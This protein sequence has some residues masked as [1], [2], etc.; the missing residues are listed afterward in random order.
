M[1]QITLILV[2]LGLSSTVLAQDYSAAKPG[3]L[4][5]VPLQALH[6]TQ[7]A[8]GYDQIYYKLG[9][10]AQ[11]RNKL[12]DEYCEANGQGESANVPGDADLRK[13]ESFTCQDK[14]G[15]RSSEM[16]T[17]VIGPEGKLFLT[18]GHHTFTVLVEHPKGGENLNMWVRVTDNFSDSADI[19]SFWQR[20]AQ[21]RKVWLKDGNG[22]AIDPQQIPSQLGLQHLAND[23]YRALVYFTREVGYDKPRSGEVAPE[24]LEFYWGNWLRS[25]MSL[26]TYDLSDRGDYRDAVE[27]AAKKM[28]ALAPEDEVGSSG[29]KARELGVYSSMDRKELNKVA[30]RKLNYATS[31]K[32][33]LA[34]KS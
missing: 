31:Y 14:V 23:P 6:P 11:E 26:D 20:M 24:F 7:A 33:A 18:D 12:F 1:R 28:V 19:A 27:T 30:G 15:A 16:K 9:R 29:F 3:E 22:Q 8:V 34:G 32:K 5:Q 13:P 17:V 2:A 25:V 10:F 21:A 4:L